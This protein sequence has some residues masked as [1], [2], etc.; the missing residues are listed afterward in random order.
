MNILRHVRPIVP[1]CMLTVAFGCGSPASTDRL[2]V[3]HD[4]T[5]VDDRAPTPLPAMSVVIE[6]THISA[7]GPAASLSVPDGAQAVDGTGGYLI[8][9]L[10]DMHTHALV[11]QFLAGAGHSSI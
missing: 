8:P 2:I 6:G 1:L 3:V 5:I 7:V 9:G 10:W 11:D 4:V